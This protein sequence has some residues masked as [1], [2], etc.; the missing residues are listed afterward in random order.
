VN[1]TGMYVGSS[2]LVVGLL[3]LRIVLQ[4]AATA[5]QTRTR[6]AVSRGRA[7]GSSASVS[8]GSSD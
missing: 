7:T 1:L 4:W 3:I 5:V 6:G 8:V 2:V